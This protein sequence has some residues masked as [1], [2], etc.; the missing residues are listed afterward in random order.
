ML[1]PK[2][3]TRVTADAS[4]PSAGAI[5]A[6]QAGIIMMTLLAP[7]PLTAKGGVAEQGLKAG[8]V[9]AP[10]GSQ[11]L[12]A[13]AVFQ[14]IPSQTG[15]MR[16]PTFTASR[17]NIQNSQMV[18]QARS[19][20]GLKEAAAQ[21]IFQLLRRTSL[22]PPSLPNGSS[23]M[24]RKQTSGRHGRQAGPGGS[25]VAMIMTVK[26]LTAATPAT[27]GGAETGDH[28]QRTTRSGPVTRVKARLERTAVTLMTKVMT[29]L[30]AAT[31]HTPGAA[32]GQT[33]AGTGGATN[34]RTMMMTHD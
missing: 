25:Q 4:A 30:R 32:T 15:M 34:G 20:S 19:L 16:L 12:Q 8:A 3:S 14:S 9:Q 27:A 26:T 29:R 11:G 22:R 6:L 13:G 2:R 21:Q 18:N 28:T 10:S 23:E 5:S 24:R 31:R 33:A 1:G 17:G 7:L